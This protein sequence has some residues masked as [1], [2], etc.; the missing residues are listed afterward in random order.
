MR[1]FTVWLSLASCAVLGLAVMAMELDEALAL[2]RDEIVV[3]EFNECGRRSLEDAIATFLDALEVPSDLH[4]LNEDAVGAVTIKM[5]D[6]DLVNRLSQTYFTLANTFLRGEPWERDV[7]L[8]GKNWGFK[9]LRMNPDFAAEERDFADA[10]ASEDDVAALYWTVMNW[11]RAAE[12]SK[13]EALF[14]GVPAK[15][16]AMLER[17]LEIDPAYNACAPHRALGGFWGGLPRLPL[18]TY[19][20]N[21]ERARAVL[22]PI[23]DEPTICPDCTECPIDPECDAFLENRLVFAE[24]YLIEKGLWE[25]AQRVLLSVLDAPV[26]DRY[27]LHNAHSHQRALE[28]LERVEA[29]L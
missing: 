3:V 2:F 28:L 1:G 6:R 9:S 4:E 7:Y 15:A 24:F 19:R 27:P 16:A 17:A 20:K 25:D 8:R 21:L 26:G 29:R 5:S 13:P 14:A 18:G 12:F 10:V 23:V 22:C 11:L